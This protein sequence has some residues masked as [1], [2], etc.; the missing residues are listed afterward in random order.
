MRGLYGIFG[1]C[2]FGWAPV[3]GYRIS[4]KFRNGMVFDFTGFTGGAALWLYKK[5]ADPN[6]IGT[7]LISFYSPNY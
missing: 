6:R 5:S 3:M 1:A 7:F 2:P 4:L